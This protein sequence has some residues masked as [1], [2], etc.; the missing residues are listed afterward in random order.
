MFS[1]PFILTLILSCHRTSI[2]EEREREGQSY[3]SGFSINGEIFT[4]PLHFIRG[5]GDRGIQKGGQVNARDE[6]TKMRTGCHNCHRI[7]ARK[8]KKK[9]KGYIIN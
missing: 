2:V 3:K 1:Y 6:Q 8:D 5:S 4:I 9:Q 7:R